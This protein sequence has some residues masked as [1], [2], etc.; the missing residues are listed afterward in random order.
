MLEQLSLCFTVLSI[1]KANLAM[2]NERLSICTDIASFL[3]SQRRTTDTEF[4]F[5]A[6]PYVSAVPLLAGP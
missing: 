5:S 1:S 3:E 6:H 4:I 2:P